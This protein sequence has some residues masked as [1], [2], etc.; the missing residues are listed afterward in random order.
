MRR[1]FAISAVPS[2]ADTNLERVGGWPYGPAQAVD[3]D[4]IRELIFLSS[5]GVVLTLDGTDPTNPQF[6]NDDIHTVGLVHDLFYDAAERDLYVA[7]GEGGLEIWDVDDPLQ[8]VRLSVI[9]IY[10]FD[11]ETPVRSVE[12]YDNYAIT[13]NSWGTNRID[14]ALLA[15]HS[16]TRIDA[17][18][19]E[20]GTPFGMPDDRKE[21][22]AGRGRKKR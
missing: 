9:E 12:V 13:E 22:L 16:R 1:L 10:Y 20:R 18:L 3:V 5:G 14:K 7:G 15:A 8:P 19:V 17:L 6:L 4:P 21:R 2:R 11:V